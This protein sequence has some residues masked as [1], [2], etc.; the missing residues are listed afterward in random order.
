LENNPTYFT[1]KEIERKE[2]TTGI[3]KPIVG[4]YARTLIL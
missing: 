4:E 3:Y 1:T 2:I